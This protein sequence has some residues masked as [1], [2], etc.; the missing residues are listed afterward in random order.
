MKK[1]F[2]SMSALLFIVTAC[3]KE[4]VVSDTT[5]VTDTTIVATE[6]AEATK[7][8]DSAAMMKAWEAYATPGEAHKTLALDNG[9]WT[10]ES[11][12]WMGP[13]DQKPM[14]S[15]MTANI[16]MIMGGRY[17]EARYSGNMMGQAFEGISTVGYDNASKEI[18]SSWLDN[19]GTNIMQMRGK[20]DGI[21]KTM[22]MKGECTDPMTGKIKTVRETYT[23]VDDN[24]RKMEMY[25]TDPN[26]K[27]FKS[28]EIVMTRKK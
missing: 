18:V 4:T 1:T 13:N 19:M 28:M 20:Y 14:K 17:Q 6:T 9:N 7:P 10:A 25:D 5:I 15:T 27:E 2:F 8:M 3:K 23:L 21:S 24:T 26:G 22:D 12:M 11:T 16:K